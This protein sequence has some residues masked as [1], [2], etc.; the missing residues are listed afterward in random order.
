MITGAELLM[1]ND[2]LAR[3]AEDA[4]GD[5]EVPSHDDNT[6]GMLIDHLED[7][8]RAGTFSGGMNHGGPGVANMPE[9]INGVDALQDGGDDSGHQRPLLAGAKAAQFGVA[10]PAGMGTAS[11]LIPL[12]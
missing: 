10:S 7:S 9:G 11:G 4:A 6:M 3:G 12:G 8:L 2:I 5:A 1:M